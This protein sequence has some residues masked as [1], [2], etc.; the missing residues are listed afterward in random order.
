MANE[1]NAT[2]HNNSGAYHSQR[3]SE[4]LDGTVLNV[5]DGAVEISEIVPA[6]ERCLKRKSGGVV[7]GG[8]TPALRTGARGGGRT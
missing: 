5:G 8:S 4:V 6:Q 7:R 2:R 3:A 1:S